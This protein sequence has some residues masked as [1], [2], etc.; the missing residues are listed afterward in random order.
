[1]RLL[2]VDDDADFRRL[3]R[4]LL[5]DGGYDVVGAAA[6]A[7]DAVKMAGECAPEVTLVDVNLPDANGFKLAGRLAREHPGMAVLL[8]S[9]YDRG[10]L[11]QL[12]RDT[13]AR[14][15]VPKDELSGPELDRRLA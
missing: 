4:Q 13:G 11:D 5:E 9:T 6:D 3:A 12:A 15:F 8:I 1:M 14:G 10:D 2:L 7:R